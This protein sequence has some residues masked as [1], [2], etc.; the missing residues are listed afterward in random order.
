MECAHITM[1][2]IL[3]GKKPFKIELKVI[4]LKSVW[5]TSRLIE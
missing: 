2:I 5:T 3:N 1:A 4:F